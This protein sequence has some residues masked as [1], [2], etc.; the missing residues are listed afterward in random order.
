MDDVTV[1][2]TWDEPMA[3]MALGLLRAEGI[4][5]RKRT[6][7]ARSVHPFT[8][9]GLGE[10]EILVPGGEKDRATEI[11]AARFSSDDGE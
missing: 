10:I 7:V 6:D 1:Y 8:M 9:D 2:T 3:D 5:A 11:L 4:Q